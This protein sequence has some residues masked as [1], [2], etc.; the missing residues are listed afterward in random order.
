MIEVVATVLLIIAGIIFI[1][2]LHQLVNKVNIGVQKK[3]VIKVTVKDDAVFNVQINRLIY[4]LRTDLHA[5]KICIARFHNGGSFNNG[6]DMKKFSITHETPLP[7]D[8]PMMSHNQA[9]LN[10]RY[11]DAFLHLVSLESYIV[12][13]IDNCTDPNF[14]SDM[15]RYGWNSTMLFLIRQFDGSDE[16]FVGIN[17]K[18]TRVLTDE[19]YGKIEEIIP[20]LLGLVNMVNEK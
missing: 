9:I 20:T 8:E 3:E 16:G 11:P 15:K 19:E 2:L 6:F 14:K 10:S 1:Y 18:Q 4:K 17:F 7:C 5:D 12:H 13:N